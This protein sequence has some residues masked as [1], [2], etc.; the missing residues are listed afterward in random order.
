P[1]LRG[2]RVPVIRRVE[3]VA[4]AGPLFG[5]ARADPCRPVDLVGVFYHAT[6]LE[7]GE[8]HDVDVHEVPGAMDRTIP[9]GPIDGETYVHSR[10]S[11]RSQLPS[12]FDRSLSR[13]MRL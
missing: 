1:G 8:R 7:L 10:A 5:L 12:T 13:R 3:R 4:R 6:L 9:V 11:L 2:R